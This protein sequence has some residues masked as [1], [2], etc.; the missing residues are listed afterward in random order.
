MIFPLIAGFFFPFITFS[1]PLT[2]RKLSSEENTVKVEQNSRN[3]RLFA[4]LRKILNRGF[5]FLE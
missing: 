4:F 3:R 1:F 5:F 2:L